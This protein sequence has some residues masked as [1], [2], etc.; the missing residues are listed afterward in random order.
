MRTTALLL[1]A[2]TPGVAVGYLILLAY[3]LRRVQPVPITFM[4]NASRQTV[5]DLQR[6][7]RSRRS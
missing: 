2:A 7:Q 1:A 5:A 6:R 3:L 4:P